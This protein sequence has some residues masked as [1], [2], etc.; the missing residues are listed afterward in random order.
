LIPCLLLEG[1]NQPRGI[2]SAIFNLFCY[3]FLT[4]NDYFR[5]MSE[6]ELLQA[7][8][9]GGSEEAFR[10]LVHRY[11]DLVYSVAK[12][13]LSDA[14]LAEDVTQIVFIRFAK[15]PPSVKTHGELVGWLHRTTLNVAI[16]TWRSE[17]RRRNRE[18]QA[19]VMEP[20]TQSAWKEIS[21]HLDD[22]VNRLGDDDRQAILL[23][24]FGEKSM[25]D[26]GAALGVSEAAAKMRVGRAVERLRKQ[27]STGGI[28]C[29]AAVLG[30]IVTERSIEAAPAALVSRLAAMRLTPAAAKG[31]GSFHALRAGFK[32]AASLLVIGLVSLCFIHFRPPRPGVVQ[33]ITPA[34]AD[35]P[36]KLV[37]HPHRPTARSVAND[38]LAEQPVEKTKILLHVLDSETGIGLPEAWIKYIFF[39][40]KGG[41]SHYI[42]T[43][44][45]GDARILEPDDATKNTGPNVF[46][47]ADNHVPK[48][49]MFNSIPTNEY[50]LRL[51]PALTIGGTVVDEQGFPV[52]AVA[53]FV[54]AAGSQSWPTGKIVANIDF[55][56]CPVTNHQDGTWICS[57]IPKDCT[58]Q[59]NLILK[60]PGYAPTVTTVPVPQVNLSRLV[61]VIERG[62][63]IAGLVSDQQGRPLPRARI[64]VLDDDIFGENKRSYTDANGLFA[65]TGMPGESSAAEQP[66]ALET[67]VAGDSV[68]RGLQSKGPW[69]VELSVQADRFAGE[70]KTVDLDQG[71]NIVNFTLSPGNVFRGHVV[72]DAG[73]PISNAVIQTDRP[74]MALGGAV[75]A[76]DWSTNT[77]ANGRFEW[78]SA[79]AQETQYSIEADGYYRLSS[80]SFR[81]DGSDHQ[82][83]LP[84]EVVK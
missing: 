71:T 50:T 81:A 17:N 70:V 6:T 23:R 37:E 52:S 56:I 4:G 12:R 67:N 62:F 26:I 32:V 82:I 46:V 79:P 8:T 74:A 49:I 10:E 7:V 36:T 11:A 47:A 25:R 30:S 1:R 34:V 31:V 24:F 84:R 66:P 45:N 28:A 41:E 19:A 9:Q 39:G 57:Y 18:Q 42:W 14:A 22:A 75:R 27:L 61:L 58:N 13:R 20:D 54:G 59:F 44:G 64:K 55:Q 15:N 16:D 51:D 5:K 33:G 83:I 48:A 65:L 40:K 63:T 73:N 68:I 69:H 60:K 76:F 80:Q 77:D 53:I 2:A 21:P 38:P 3:L 29:T 35:K 78:N 72:D 43:D